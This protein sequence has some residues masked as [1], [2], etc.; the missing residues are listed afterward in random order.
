[1]KGPRK[2][3][4]VKFKGVNLQSKFASRPH[5]GGTLEKEAAGLAPARHIAGFSLRNEDGAEVA[6]IFDARVAL[7]GDCVILQLNGDLPK[8]AQLWYGRCH[9]PYCNLTDGLDMAAPVF[10]PIPLDDVK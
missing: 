4:I 6:S 9:N 8:K 7:S 10:G 1:V 2:S 5:F 3:L